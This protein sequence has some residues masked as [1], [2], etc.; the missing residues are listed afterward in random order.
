M[1]KSCGV[2]KCT[3]IKIITK[4][5]TTG[6]KGRPGRDGRD[7][8]ISVKDGSTGNVANVKELRFTDPNAIVT[9][10]S[11]GV[12]QVNFTPAATVWNDIQN[13][14]WY[15][16]NPATADFSP[17]YTIDRNKISFRGKLYIPLDGV[18]IVANNS[19]L[20]VASAVIDETKLSVISNANTNNGTP[21]GRFMTTDIT[22]LKK[23]TI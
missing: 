4:T 2:T 16:A 8:F 10:P 7:A 12:A 1:C 14:S 18:Q 6:S 9:S 11:S 20:S 23:P 17:Q 13:L 21:Q 15:T 3:C 19:Y 5:G 22:T